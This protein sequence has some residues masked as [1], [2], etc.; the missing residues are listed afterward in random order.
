MSF[1]YIFAVSFPLECALLFLFFGQE[2]RLAQSVVSGA[3]G[4]A[5]DSK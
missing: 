3:D 4:D 1:M 5:V 2:D